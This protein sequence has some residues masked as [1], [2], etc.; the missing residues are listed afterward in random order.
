MEGNDEVD[1]LEVNDHLE[2]KVDTLS[3]KLL[4]TDNL[5]IVE[6]GREWVLVCQV[7]LCQL[8]V[9]EAVHLPTGHGDPFQGIIMESNTNQIRTK[10]DI[11]LNPLCSI[12]GSKSDSL[13]TVLRSIQTGSTM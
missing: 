9:G 7:Q 10:A 2:I 1:S 6:A 4:D 13:K 11:K 5:D 3:H 12:L 8:G